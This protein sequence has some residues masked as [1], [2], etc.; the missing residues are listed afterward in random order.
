[1]YRIIAFGAFKVSSHP[2]AA[3]R[4]VP[5]DAW[6]RCHGRLGRWLL[7]DNVLA[8]Y[9]ALEESAQTYRLGSI[10]DVGIGYVTG[11]NDFFHL[12]PSLTRALGI[13]PDLL[14]V[15]VRKE[16]CFPHPLI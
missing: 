1:M 12:R 10:A 15:T 16:N 11:A 5:L 7:P 8:A 2:P 4:R 9:E 3:F 14:K 13:P 6:E